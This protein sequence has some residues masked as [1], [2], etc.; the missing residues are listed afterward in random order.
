MHTSRIWVEEWSPEY[1]A[2]TELDDGWAATEE[3]VDPFVETASWRP[4]APEPSALPRTAFID[5]VDRVE[6]RAALDHGPAPVPGL[7][8]S[9]GAGAVVVDGTARFEACTVRRAAVFGSGIRPLL[10][11]MSEPVSYLGIG[12]PG[13]RPEELRRELQRV[14]T[15]LEEDLSRTLAGSGYLVLVDG[16]LRVRE[17]LDLVGFIKR[18]HKS[19]LT[20]DLQAV[21]TSLR[22]GER[23]PVFMF[24]AIRPRYSWY[25]RLADVE[26]QHPWAATSRCEVSTTLGLERAVAL[27][28]LVTH[29]LPRFASKPFWDAR[30]PQ[31]LVPIA[32]LERK[33]WS[34]LGDRQLIYRRIRSALR[35]RGAG[36]E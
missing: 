1:G 7:F 16:P 35:V 22:K 29:H 2:S 20:P 36:D 10:P 15:G 27:A 26:N 34:L 28:D 4:V 6:A 32:T 8:G 19:Y 25:V 5:G 9:V 21:A 33:L 18:H 14:R 31:N 24:G 3:E 17:P 11:A 12:A 13:T 23:T 30:A